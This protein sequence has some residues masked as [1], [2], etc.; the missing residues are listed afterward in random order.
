MLTCRSW[1]LWNWP[2]CRWV[3]R[4]RALR[5]SPKPSPWRISRTWTGEPWSSRTCRT[6]ETPFRSWTARRRRSPTSKSRPLKPQ[7]G[8]RPPRLQVY[9]S[10]W[11]PS[12][13]IWS[14]SMVFNFEQIIKSIA[15]RNILEKRKKVET[16]KV[17]RWKKLLFRTCRC[18]QAMTKHISRTVRPL[19]MASSLGALSSDQTSLMSDS[20]IGPFS[21]TRDIRMK[22]NWK[23][24]KRKLWIVSYPTPFLKIRHSCARVAHILL[25]LRAKGWRSNIIWAPVCT[26]RNSW[27]MKKQ[28]YHQ[29][30]LVRSSRGISHWLCLS[31]NHWEVNERWI[32]PDVQGECY[33]KRK[34]KERIFFPQP[35]LVRYRHRVQQMTILDPRPH[36]RSTLV[37]VSW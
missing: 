35:C 12:R 15:Q 25:K 7:P 5:G 18:L 20:V 26:G 22:I 24:A 4:F 34:K 2:T 37:W 9:N 17:S 16:V 36:A 19:R 23:K 29:E 32:K 21:P 33:P 31:T 13:I 10:E 1:G 27:L 11:L 3:S 28:L 8:S 30:T 6:R 14:P